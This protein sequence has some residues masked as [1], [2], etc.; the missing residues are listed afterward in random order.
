MQKLKKPINSG[1]CGKMNTH[2]PGFTDPFCDFFTLRVH[3]NHAST[4]SIQ[5]P[6]FFRMQSSF[7]FWIKISPIRRSSVRWRAWQEEH[8]TVGKEGDHYKN[9]HNIKHH[10]RLSFVL[11]YAVKL[12]TKKRDHSSEIQQWYVYLFCHSCCLPSFCIEWRL[13]KPFEMQLHQFMECFQGIL[14]YEKA[15]LKLG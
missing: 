14:K 6:L 11:S 7:S 4:L 8:T 2:I 12:T 5:S 1:Y 15:A 9:L 13:Q 10:Q 3:L